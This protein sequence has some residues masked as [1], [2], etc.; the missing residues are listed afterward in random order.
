MSPSRIVWT[1]PAII[2]PTGQLKHFLQHQASSCTVNHRKNPGKIDN[3]EQ[4]SI[5][6]LNKALD[7]LNREGP[8]QF[9]A[10]HLQSTPAAPNLAEKRNS[11]LSEQRRRSVPQ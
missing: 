5:H 11:R 3:S 6:T 7:L 9:P 2:T 4:G 8:S 1:N 10:P